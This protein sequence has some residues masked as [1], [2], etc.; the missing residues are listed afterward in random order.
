MIISYL[1]VYILVLL[2][3]WKRLISD[4]SYKLTISIN[5]KLKTE[6]KVA[7]K[8]VEVNLG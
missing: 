4:H 7:I 8:K 3:I 5:S 2:P 6:V 1:G